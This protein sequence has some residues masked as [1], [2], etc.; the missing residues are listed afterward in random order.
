MMQ[1]P[2]DITKCYIRKFTCFKPSTSAA[3]YVDPGNTEALEI[4]D[5]NDFFKRKIVCKLVGVQRGSC[6]CRGF[7]VNI[8]SVQE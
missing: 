6:N 8:P 5:L 4:N 1:G 3:K 7:N 2:I